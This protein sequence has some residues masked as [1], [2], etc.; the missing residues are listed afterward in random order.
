MHFLESHQRIR[1]NL[2]GLISKLKLLRIAMRVDLNDVNIFVA[3]FDLIGALLSNVSQ[4]TQHEEDVNM[5][6]ICQES[7]YFILNLLI[8]FQIQSFRSN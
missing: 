3:L 8:Y 5:I 7:L 4:L 1:I 6:F 2:L